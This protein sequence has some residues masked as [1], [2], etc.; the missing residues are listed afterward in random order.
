MPAPS[1]HRLSGRRAEAAANDQII[2]EA[3]RAVFIADRTAPI[4]AVAE[5]AG[6]GISA[7]YRR[8][9]SKEELLRTLCGEGLLRFIEVT[10]A[11]LADDRDPWVAFVEFM[12]A[13]VDADTN[14][15]TVALAGTFT[16]TPEL[17][18]NGARA[19]ELLSALFERTRDAGVLRT[20]LEV[21]DLSL[22]FEQLAAI[23][24]GDG[25]RSRELRRRHLA[26]ILDG[27]RGGDGD[28]LPGPAPT[29][30]EINQRWA[31]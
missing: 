5:R 16:P 6:V 31:G 28:P 7:L 8:Y 14:S 19:N 1:D 17:W 26:L 21:H 2:L 23:R 27:M 29:W 13:A 24:T 20:D 4:A 10:E 15:L 11:A 30:E 18:R 22:V 25:Q 3:A 12:R 9:P